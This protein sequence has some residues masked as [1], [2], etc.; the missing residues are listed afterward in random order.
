V[1]GPTYRLYRFLALVALSIPTAVGAQ[2]RGPQAATQ[3]NAPKPIIAYPDSQNGLKQLANDI[4]KAQ[5]ENDPARAGALLES[6]IIPNFREW[7]A[8]NFSEA[9][10][11]RAVPAYTAAVPSLAAHLAGIFL[12]AQQEGFRNIEAVRFDDEQS[13]CSSAPVFSAMTARRTQVALYEL[14]FAHGDRF[15]RVFAFAYVDGAFRLVLVPDFSKPANHTSTQAD[16]ATP[17]GEKPQD[18]L[19]A[20][21]SV[22]AARLVCRVQPYY[23]EDARAQHISGTVR[24]HTI[25]GTD[26]SVKQL[27][28]VSGPPILVT[29]AKWA[30][31]QWRYRPVL[32]NGEPVEVDTTIDVIFSLNP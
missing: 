8:Q 10:A 12:S 30:V 14:R 18:R 9:A 19:G 25:I 23:P 13:A 7:Y 24:F 15:K 32:L 1:I 2:S 17:K 31:S 11:A 28:A 21:Q 5:K 6:F 20:V 3:G 16:S 22:Q 26:G 27:D 29:A 4:L